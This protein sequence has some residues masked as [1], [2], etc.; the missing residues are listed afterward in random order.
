MH[1]TLEDFKYMQSK[2]NDKST[3]LLFG[4]RPTYFYVCSG[5]SDYFP[6]F[7]PSLEPGYIYS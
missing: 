3:Y 6:Q 4:C 5:V 7:L 2:H 1:S